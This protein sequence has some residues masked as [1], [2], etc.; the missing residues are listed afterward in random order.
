M[1]NEDQEL[2]KLKVSINESLKKLGEL[3][4]ALMLMD[5]PRGRDIRKEWAQQLSNTDKQIKKAEYMLSIVHKEMQEC[6]DKKKVTAPN[7]NFIFVEK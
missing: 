4:K 2:R 1:Q 7:Y 5:L 3:H 6:N